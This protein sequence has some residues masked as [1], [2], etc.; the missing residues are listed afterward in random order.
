MSTD[1]SDFSRGDKLFSVKLSYSSVFQSGFK[2]IYFVFVKAFFLF[3]FQLFSELVVKVGLKVV[4]EETVV[5]LFK[6]EGEVTRKEI[7]TAVGDSF[8]GG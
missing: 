2:T 7:L 4:G 6:R 8:Q 1:L 5:I 3:G